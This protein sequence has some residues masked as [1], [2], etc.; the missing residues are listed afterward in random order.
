MQKQYDSYT[1]AKFIDVGYI[2]GKLEQQGEIKTNF[3]SIEDIFVFVDELHKEWVTGIKNNIFSNKDEE[4]YFG[5]FAQRKI[6]EIYGE[7]R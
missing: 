7:N 1:V 6:V 2:I 5:A 3:N 4:G